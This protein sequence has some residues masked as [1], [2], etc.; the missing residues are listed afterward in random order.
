MCDEPRAAHSEPQDTDILAIRYVRSSRQI[1][2]DL[3]HRR[4]EILEETRTTPPRKIC[5]QVDGLSRESLNIRVLRIVSVFQPRWG[6][7]NSNVEKTLEKVF[8]NHL[9]PHHDCLQTNCTKIWHKRLT[10]DLTYL[11]STTRK[12]E[13]VNSTD[14]ISD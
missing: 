11:I 7:F 1:E 13:K 8:K 4:T 3:L 5:T 6:V 9:G 10:E 12:A 2:L 14:C